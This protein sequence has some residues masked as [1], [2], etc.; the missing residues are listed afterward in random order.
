VH[1]TRA[2]SR[3]RLEVSSRSYIF[4]RNLLEIVGPINSGLD[5]AFTFSAAARGGRRRLNGNGAGDTSLDEDAISSALANEASLWSNA[6]DLWHA[7]GWAFNCSIRHPDRWRFWKIWLGYMLDVLDADWEQRTR[8]DNAA[9]EKQG[10]NSDAEEIFTQREN[11]LLLK[12]LSDH[13]GRAN[14]KRIVKSLFADGTVE[15]LKMFPEV[16]KNETKARKVDGSLK[17]KRDQKVDIEHDSYGDY[18]RNEENDLVDTSSSP[19]PPSSAPTDDADT[20]AADELS[21]RMATLGGP[22]SIELRQRV[23]A[24]VSTTHEIHGPQ[25]TKKAFACILL[26]P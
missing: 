1:T 6:E 17:R 13:N 14:V 8:L 15:Y 5:D 19:A 24:L 23:M 26:H 4:L 22:E 12:Y 2:S 11:S 10:E 9:S 25:L 18:L 21:E 3:D 7:V 16:F 20:T